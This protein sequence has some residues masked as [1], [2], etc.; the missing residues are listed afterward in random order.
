M[1]VL[2][3]FSIYLY[4]FAIYC[5]SLFNPK[6]KLWLAGRRNW[7]NSLSKF[8]KNNELIWFHCASLGEFDQGLPVMREIKRV[9]PK[10]SI[11]VTFFSPSGMLHY[12]KRNHCADYFHYLPLDTAQNA[13][14]FID[15]F[16]PSKIYFVKYEFWVN[17][18]NVAAN[19]GIPIYSISANFRSNQHF[20]KW[21][22]SFFRKMLNQFDYFFVQTDE[23][24]SLLNSIGL[25]N[26]EVI[27][28]T[29][30]D[31]VINTKNEFIQ[32]IQSGEIDDAFVH[33]NSFLNGQKAIILGSSWP[34]EEKIILPFLLNSPN[35]KFIFAPHDISEKHISY[36][37]KLLIGKSVR[38]TQLMHEKENKQCLI[39]DTIG[40]LTKAY[41]FGELAIVGGGF[42]GKL[43]NI[44]EPA[45]FGLPVLF[46]PHH[47]RFPEASLFLENNIAFQ[48]RNELE[49]QEIIT[50]IQF[51]DNRSKIERMVH[52]LA[53][54]SARIIEMAKS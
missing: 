45:V 6:A 14:Y 25:Q 13:K 12:S 11:L 36:L 53:G 30:I 22:G 31:Q 39:L 33:L 44:L 38:F 4:G 28:D 10:C 42:T 52:S 49:L 1:N 47:Q 43:H 34:V 9:N 19:K 46:G 51:E 16:S 26:V 40:H 29:R 35:T 27:G 32:T 54:A 5:A 48:F 7:K 41:Y 50:K 2:Y 24:K 8:D 37:Q 17:F 3:N 15:Y 20:F 18:I 21:Y 23:S